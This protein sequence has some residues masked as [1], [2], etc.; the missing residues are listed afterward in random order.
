[1][2][3]R[4]SEAGGVAEAVVAAAEAELETPQ[5]TSGGCFYSIQVKRGGAGEFQTC[6]C[7]DLGLAAPLW[8]EECLPLIGFS[9]KGEEPMELGI[10]E[11]LCL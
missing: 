9:C 1:M 3:V 7:T 2:A 5:A 4:P 10:K 6:I 11:W 8:G